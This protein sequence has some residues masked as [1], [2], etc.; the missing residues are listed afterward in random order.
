MQ[1]GVIS[2]DMFTSWSPVLRIKSTLLDLQ[3]LL[4]LY[5]PMP[6][7]PQAVE[8][9]SMAMDR[10]KRFLQ[11]RLPVPLSMTDRASYTKDAVLKQK[12]LEPNDRIAFADS[13]P[14]EHPSEYLPSFPNLSF[15]S[16]PISLVRKSY[17][18]EEKAF[19]DVAP[20]ST[21]GRRKRS[22]PKDCDYC[23]TMKVKVSH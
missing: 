18:A 17:E 20:D 14:I 4:I 22:M 10:R 16:Y 15:D 23:R 11:G 19:D 21:L 3:S 1:K 12:V 6:D 2:F 13:P 5:P 7:N 9:A 8:V